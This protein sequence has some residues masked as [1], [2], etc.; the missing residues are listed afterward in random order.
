MRADNT[1]AFGALQLPWTCAP[2]PVKSNT[3]EPYKKESRELKGS[4][5]PWPSGLGIEFKI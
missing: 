5:D 3:A 2:V 4:V 1:T